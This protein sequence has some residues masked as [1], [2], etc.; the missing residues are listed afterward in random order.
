MVKRVVDDRF[1]LVSV[2]GSGGMATVHRAIDLKDNN[3][4]VAVKIFDG[5]KKKGA[6]EVSERLL[7]RFKKEASLLASMKKSPHVPCYIADGL[8]DDGDHYIAMELIVG[9]TLRRLIQRSDRGIEAA[10]FLTIADQIVSGLLSIHRHRILHR[11]LCPDNIMLLQPESDQVFVKFLDFGLGRF[12]Q[13]ET[14]RVTTAGTVFGKPSYLSPE[15]SL[16]KPQS[17]D[18][19]VYSLG[20]VLYEMLTG[21]LPLNI[22][23]MAELP[24]VRREAPTP[25]VE[26]AVATRI[27]ASLRAL[28][29]GCLEKQRSDRPTLNEMHECLRELLRVQKRGLD[30]VEDFANWE[31]SQVSVEQGEIPTQFL[32]PGVLFGRWKAES[33]IR[34]N[35]T[36]ETWLSVDTESGARH[37]ALVFSK[38][39]PGAERLLKTSRRVMEID[40]ENIVSIRDVLTTRH[41]GFVVSKASEAR[42]LQE[43]LDLDGTFEAARTL[44]VAEGVLAGLQV[45]H[46]LRKPLVHGCLAPEHI[47]IDEFDGVQLSSAGL[48]PGGANLDPFDEKSGL[49]AFAAPEVALGDEPTPRADIFS[50]GCIL[51]FISTGRPPV[52]GGAVSAVYCHANELQTLPGDFTPAQK[53]ED[54]LLLARTCMHKNPQERPASVSAVQEELNR[55]FRT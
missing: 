11:D 50:F 48:I 3:R 43:A 18:S 45:L 32:D 42:T 31:L 2:I 23:S 44:G 9:K 13:G 46:Q 40:H 36:E 28:I 5:H 25:L 37:L 30:L 10:L 24:A 47:L 33:V 29:M 51:W 15:Q 49:L 12:M 4:S 7:M 17:A 20:V 6:A 52:D 41:L 54:L 27:P 55:I 38:S 34:A 1:Q 16:G 14:E 19:D 39:Q 53:Q 8:S 35:A 21:C 26:H 22:H